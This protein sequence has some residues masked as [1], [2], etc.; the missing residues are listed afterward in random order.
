MARGWRNES[1][2]HSLSAKG[3]RTV[4]RNKFVGKGVER[5]WHK[6]TRG[7]AERILAGGFD[8]SKRGSGG[9]GG[10][11]DVLG[12]SLGGGEYA[13]S[14]EMLAYDLGVPV[15][16]IVSLRVV[17]KFDKVFDSDYGIVHRV[18]GG[19]SERTREVLLE[20]GYDAVRFPSGE[21]VALIP[22]NLEVVHG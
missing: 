14:D 1:H 13:Y 4:P 3:I 20:R 21:V 7:R 15:K 9:L 5:L 8:L 10:K 11:T 22:E 17:G 19:S 18:G 12:V 2:R 16:E 6:T